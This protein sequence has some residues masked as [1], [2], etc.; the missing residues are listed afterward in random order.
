MTLTALLACVVIG[1][2]LVSTDGLLVRMLS[3][4]PLTAVGLVSYGV[5]LWNEVFLVLLRDGTG[6]GQ[7][8]RAALIVVLIA[9][10]SAL[11]WR[12]VELPI[13]RRTG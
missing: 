6:I 2:V 4:R 12:V 7:Y 13:L 3:W 1:S 9:A 10:A 8:Q 5:Y 11:S